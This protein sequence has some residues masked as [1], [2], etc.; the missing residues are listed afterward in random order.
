MKILIT[1]ICGFAGST[2]ALQLREAKA[3]LEIF[4]V[5]NFIRAGSE[6]NRQ[7][8]G[9][10]GIPV[11]H[12]DVRI[13]EDLATLPKADWVIDAAAQPSVLAG[14]SGS[15]TNS[16]QLMQHNLEGTLNILEYCRLHRAGFILLSTSRVYS[17]APLV[18][19]TMEVQE[20]AFAPIIKQSWPQGVSSAGVSETF[21]TKSPVSLYGASKICSETLALEYGLTFDFPV[22]IN[23]L[24]VLAGA[25]QFGRADQGIFSF[26]IHSCAAK[27]PLKFIGFGGEGFQVRDCLHPR[28]LV[29]VLLQQMTC[30]PNPGETITNFS[31]GKANS[32]SLRQLHDWCEQRYGAHPV[33]KEIVDRPFDLPWMVLDS[34]LAEKR[35]NWKAATLL[36]TILDEI[37]GHAEQ[38]PHWLDLTAA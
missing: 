30:V 22:W 5:D 25:G 19:L 4:G 13:S 21:S 27:R 9:A 23:R 36:P 20:K 2:L 35:F 6:L 15:S 1:G 17:I 7:R 33:Q 18:A 34:S 38:N 3:G 32:M 8:M 14:T 11:F 24:G 37:A 10:E 26:W 16:R 28:D 29:G 12:A 31:G